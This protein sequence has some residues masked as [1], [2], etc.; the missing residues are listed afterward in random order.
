MRRFQ[1]ILWIALLWG[2][3][4]WEETQKG[5]GELRSKKEDDKDVKRGNGGAWRRKAGKNGGVEM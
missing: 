2:M 3:A 5:G 4:A 1:G